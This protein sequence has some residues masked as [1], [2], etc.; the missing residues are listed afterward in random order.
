MLPAIPPLAV[1]CPTRPHEPVL[2]AY[3]LTS[4]AT[5]EPAMTF[6]DRV[7]LLCLYARRV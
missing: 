7:Y 3:T 2:V 4:A 5:A 6:P 1:M